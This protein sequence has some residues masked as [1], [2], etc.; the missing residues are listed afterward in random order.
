ME[1]IRHLVYHALGICGESHT[2]LLTFLLG[3]NQFLNYINHIIK[4][5]FK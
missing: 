1:E 3:E 5:K 2:N 4:F